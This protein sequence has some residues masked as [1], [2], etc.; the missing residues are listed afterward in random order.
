MK[1][2]RLYWGVDLYDNTRSQPKSKFHCVQIA[3]RRSREHDSCSN[4]FC[5]EITV[6]SV[7][8]PALNPQRVLSESES[9]PQ[10]AKPVFP[11]SR[12]STRHCVCERRVMTTNSASED[13]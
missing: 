13:H 8:S 1:R 11:T 9:F 5:A 2:A 7:T 3:Q 10:T 12:D 4:D 6:I